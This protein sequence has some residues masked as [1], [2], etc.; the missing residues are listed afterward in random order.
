M[1]KVEITTKNVEYLWELYEE[2]LEECKKLHYSDYKPKC[3]EDFVESEVC[4]CSNCGE[5]VTEEHMGTSEL[6]LQDNICDDCMFNGY[7]E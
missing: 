4:Q 3:F 1:E 2:Y 6:A 5:Y 7:G